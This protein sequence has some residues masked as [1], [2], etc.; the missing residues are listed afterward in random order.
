MR[1]GACA[2]EL[3]PEKLTDLHVGVGVGVAGADRAHGDVQ[4]E[5]VR[6]FGGVPHRAARPF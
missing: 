4:A 6:T 2:C 3:Q 5:W 1:A